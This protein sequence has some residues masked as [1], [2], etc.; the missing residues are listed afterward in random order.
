MYV[1]MYVGVGVGV[2]MYVCM[3]VCVLVERLVSFVNV[4]GA[5]EEQ[6]TVSWRAL[7]VAVTRAGCIP[8]A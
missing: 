2:C 1:C 4:L 7:V 8:L 6:P 5:G 3:Y